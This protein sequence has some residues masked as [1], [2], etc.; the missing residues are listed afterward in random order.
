MRT[1]AVKSKPRTLMSRTLGHF[2][3]RV[4]VVFVLT[5]PL[6]FL[7]HRYAYDN[8]PTSEILLTLSMQFLL[9]FLVISVAYFLT[10]RYAGRRLWRPFDDTL[11]KTEHFNIAKDEVPVFNDTDISEF[12]RLNRSLEQLMAR[13]HESFRIQKEFT[14][15]ASHELQTPLAVMRSKLDLLM[16]EEMNERQMNIVSDLYN[17][18]MRM[19][20]LNRNLLLLA[21][22]ENA[23]Y[24]TTEEVDIATLLAETLPLYGVIQSGV[25]V[26][27]SD[28]RNDRRR[29]LRANKVLL[30]CLLKNLMV[31]ALRNTPEGGDVTVTLTDKSMI[32]SNTAED[33][34]L[35]DEL[36]FRRFRNGA[37][38]AHGNGLGLAIVR[39]VCDYHRWRVDYCFALGRHRFGVHFGNG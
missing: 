28:L 24:A 20:H 2:L 39:S 19:S 36:L 23:Q 15:N 7:L 37:V 16:Q 1:S 5:G 8:D 38:G 12:N 31:N 22:I 35:D 9:I 3:V 17:L 21:K 29:H 32:V 26:S 25:P 6:F 27:V 10:L 14:E 4:T 34:S 33:G 13:D 30:E 11:K 18:T